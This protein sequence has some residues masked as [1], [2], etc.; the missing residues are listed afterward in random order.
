MVALGTGLKPGMATHHNV[1]LGS[2]RLVPAAVGAMKGKWMWWYRHDAPQKG[3]FWLSLPLF[4]IDGRSI[5][6]RLSAISAFG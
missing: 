2:N 3:P 4:D 6:H 5:D 1:A